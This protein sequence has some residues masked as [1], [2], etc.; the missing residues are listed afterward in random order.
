MPHDLKVQDFPNCLEV[1]KY[2]IIY[3]Y[4]MFQCISMYF[5]VFQCV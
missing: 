3:F 5:N 4:N 2:D 1:P